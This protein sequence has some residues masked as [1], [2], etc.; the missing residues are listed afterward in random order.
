MESNQKIK[1]IIE[2]LGQHQDEEAIMVLEKIGT[3]SDNDEIRE[4]TAK[5]LVQKN[6]EE[7][8]RIVLISRGK[9]INDLSA[10]VAMSTINELVSLKDKDKAVKILDDTIDM[11]SEEDIRETARSVR[12]L[13]TFSC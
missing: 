6:T 12:T 10:R 11:H 8:L 5:A 2:A 9:G 7:S 1:N 4:L 13:L 3:N